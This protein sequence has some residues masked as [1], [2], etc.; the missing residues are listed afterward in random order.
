MPEKISSKMCTDFTFY[1]AYFYDINVFFWPFFA[2]L[3]EKSMKKI[4]SHSEALRLRDPFALGRLSSRTVILSKSKYFAFK[5]TGVRCENKV[6]KY[7]SARSKGFRNI[8]QYKRR[9][10]SGFSFTSHVV[11]W[12][13]SLMK[14]VPTAQS[15]YAFPWDLGPT[16]NRVSY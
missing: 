4:S 1:I 15:D 5:W 16:Q 3:L 7:T 8:D 9:S 14:L 2:K 13:S 11:P 12:W 10:S 6:V